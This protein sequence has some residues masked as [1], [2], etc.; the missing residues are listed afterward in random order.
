MMAAVPT[1]RPYDDRDHA[2]VMGLADRL[3]QGAQPWRDGERWL[4]VVRGWVAE[5]VEAATSPRHGLLVAVDGADQVEGF[6]A[7]ST[8]THFTGDVDAYVGELV[9]ASGHE[10]RGI[11]RA[12]LRAA[13]AWAREQG[14]SVLTLDTGGA[15]AQ[16]RALYEAEGFVEEDVRLTKPLT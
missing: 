8:R 7:V 3:T 15:N 2:S 16:A 6:V 5:S 12:L 1:I 14:F 10:R 9:V 13:E 11:G 4:A